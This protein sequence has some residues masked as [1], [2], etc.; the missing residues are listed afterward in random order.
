MKSVAIVLA[1]VLGGCVAPVAIG[2]DSFPSHP[3]CDY[4]D[5][6]APWCVV[7]GKLECYGAEAQSYEGSAVCVWRCQSLGDLRL[8]VYGM[9]NLSPAITLDTM[10]ATSPAGRCE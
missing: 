7:D 3:A 9:F 4:T 8:D 5:P 2:M 6:D 1:F 10:V